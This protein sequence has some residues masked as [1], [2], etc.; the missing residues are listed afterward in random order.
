MT[1]ST[2]ALPR[3]LA[4]YGALYGAF[5]VLSPYLPTLLADRGLGPE[6]IGVLLA[7][8]TAV[9]LVAGPAAGRLA[10]R[11]DAPALVLAACCG[12]A[13]LASFGY[14]TARGLAMLLAV[15][16]GHAAMLAPLA[17]LTDSLA[18]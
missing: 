13:A 4:L 14:L 18:L 7:A 15:A 8:G 17:P 9:R 6:S 3:F 16:V 10:D 11:L 5:G 12:A 1:F 2:P